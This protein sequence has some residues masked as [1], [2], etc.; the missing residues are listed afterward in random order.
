MVATNRYRWFGKTEYCSLLTDEQRKFL[1]VD[2]PQLWAQLADWLIGG[3]RPFV[4]G[5][6]SHTSNRLA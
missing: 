4:E 1:V 3:A 6:F 5:C 2:D